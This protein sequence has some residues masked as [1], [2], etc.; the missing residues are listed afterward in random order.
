M[1]GWQ[2]IIHHHL[3][4]HKV[5]PSLHPQFNEIRHNPNGCEA[6]MRL[7]APCHPAF[8][9]NGILIQP[10]PRQ[11][12]RSLDEHFRRCE[13]FCFTQKC[14]LNTEHSWNK[15][16]HI[17]RFLNSCE[18]SNVLRTLYNQEKNVLDCFY[19]FSC[20]RIVATIKEH[21][22]SP[23]F[24]LLGGRVR[25]AP[26]AARPATTGVGTAPVSCPAP[27]AT[28]CRFS[29][30]GAGGTG[31]GAGNGT[32]RSGAT[33]RSPRDRQVH[34]IAASSPPSL[35]DDDASVETV[36]EMIVAKLNG[37]CLGGCGKVHP[38]HECPNLVGDVEHQKKTFASLSGKRQF[39]R[40]RAITAETD[41]GDDVNLINLGDPGAED[42]DTDQAFP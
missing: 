30:S 21:I 27:G 17:V 12:C 40:V 41:D 8:T 23:S 11:G 6:L 18:N 36:K 42:S 3:K 4:R 32:Q 24:A 26:T 20:E 1:S 35:L 9:D 33:G 15:E 38:P 22:D 10:H 28:R 31:T 7:I 19:K 5:I 14:H 16:I 29:H 2:A 25:Q 13:F 34:A 39:L 37:E